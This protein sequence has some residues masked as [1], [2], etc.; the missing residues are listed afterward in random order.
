[1]QTGGVARSY[2]LVGRQAAAWHGDV[3][4]ARKKR[5]LAEPP[6]CLLTTPESLEG[7]LVS[8]SI[9]HDRLFAGVRAVVVDEVHA[10]GRDDRGWH[11]LALLQRI[12]RL[13]GR[14]LQPIGLSAAVGNEDDLPELLSGRRPARSPSR[15]SCST[16][17]AAWRTPARSSR[18]CTAARNGW[19]SATAGP[20]SSNWPPTCG[21]AGSRRSS[22]TARWASTKDG[23]PNGPSP[24]AA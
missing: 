7:M 12:G 3:T 15:R 16:T 13:A 9:R 10:F 20:G 11:L 18:R 4:A 19:S 6:D 23:R 14:D 1:N 2:G 8:A 22:R 17:S 5:M 24:R 21:P